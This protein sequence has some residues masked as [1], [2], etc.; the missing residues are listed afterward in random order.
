MN[1]ESG[2]R[3][4]FLSSLNVCFIDKPTV[5]GFYRFSDRR[6]SSGIDVI[7]RLIPLFFLLGSPFDSLDRSEQFIAFDFS[8]RI[9]VRIVAIDLVRKNLLSGNGGNTIPFE[10]GEV[11]L[12]GGRQDNLIR[13]RQMPFPPIPDKMQLETIV[14]LILGRAITLVGNLPCNLALAIAAAAGHN[15][16]RVND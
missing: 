2:R 5:E 1:N 15:R 6:N 13:E 16:H 8:L 14:I 3:P 11:V 7:S 10:H 4:A 12:R 9:P